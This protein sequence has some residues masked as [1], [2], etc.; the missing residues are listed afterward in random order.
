MAERHLRPATGTGSH[1][2][3]RA[4][5][6]PLAEVYG[7]ALLSLDGVICRGTVALPHAVGALA[8]ARRLGLRPVVVTGADSPAH[9]EASAILRSIGFPA[10]GDDPVMPMPAV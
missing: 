6:R 7:T 8:W 1:Q 4:S 9:G 2:S 10:G 5:I 3:L